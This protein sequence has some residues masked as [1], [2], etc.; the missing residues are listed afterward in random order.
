MQERNEEERTD[1][2]Y[3]LLHAG[4][5]VDYGWMMRGV[6][7]IHSVG[8][9]HVNYGTPLNYESQVPVCVISGYDQISRGR[10]TYPKSLEN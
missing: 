9:P 10:E 3:L 7:K 2:K 5:R 8:F 6:E 1:L 4:G